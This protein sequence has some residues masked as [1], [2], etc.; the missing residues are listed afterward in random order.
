MIPL[1]HRRTTYDGTDAEA[2]ARW[3]RLTRR[4]AQA[5]R[6]EGGGPSGPLRLELTEALLIAHDLF[7]LGQISHAPSLRWD[8]A[9]AESALS[10]WAV[11]VVPDGA[12]T[13]DRQRS[14][15]AD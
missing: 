1:G 15:V 4:A 10:A 7:M 13:Q 8:I 5:S 9:T 12:L 6:R 3:E 11:T 14:P 2:A